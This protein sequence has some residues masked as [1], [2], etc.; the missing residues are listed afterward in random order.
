MFLGEIVVHAI[1]TD[2]ERQYERAA[3]ERRMLAV[4]ESLPSIASGSTAQLGSKTRPVT[5]ETRGRSANVPA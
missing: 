1:Q 4:D 2:R 5:S 3:R